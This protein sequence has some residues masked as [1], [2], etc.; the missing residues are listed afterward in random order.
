MSKKTNKDFWNV[1][2]KNKLAVSKP[3]NFAVFVKEFLNNYSSTIV[4]VGC[5]NGRDL[6]YFKKNKFDIMGIDLSKNAVS[7]IKK[8]LKDT[9]DK[10]KIIHSD[11]ARF[12]YKK[13]VKKKFSIYSRFT[14]HTINE[15]SEVALLKKISKIPNL[16]YIFIET[17]SDKDELC[18]VGKKISKNEFVTDHYRRFINKNNLVKKIKKSFKIIYLKES[19][20]FSKFKKEDP[21]LIRLI[22]IRKSIKT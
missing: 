1:F 2:Y 6:F 15:R 5:G 17:R 14:W 21:C 11:F 18:G 22:A 10:K 8:G 12:D 19:K 3:S 13:N 16:E 20:G 4:D 9:K 7:L